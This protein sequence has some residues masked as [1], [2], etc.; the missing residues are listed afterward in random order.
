MDW[1]RLSP[2]S[3]DGVGMGKIMGIAE[4]RVAERFDPN[5]RKKLEKPNIIQSLLN[6]GLTQEETFS[7]GLQAQTRLRLLSE[8]QCSVP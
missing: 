7:T 3:Q 4:E 6:N 1:K 8:Q 5:S 2:T